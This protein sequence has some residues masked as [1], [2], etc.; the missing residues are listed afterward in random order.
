MPVAAAAL[1][2]SQPAAALAPALAPPQQ[3][4]RRAVHSRGRRARL[5]LDRYILC[6]ALT[7]PSGL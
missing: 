4:R 1:S 2:A 6:H 3:L 7:L 5:R